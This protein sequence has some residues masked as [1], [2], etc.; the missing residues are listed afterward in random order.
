MALIT[1]Y[2]TTARP[3]RGII[4]VYDSDAYI[5]DDETLQNSRTQVVAGNGYHLY[6]HSLQPDIP[7]EIV[8]RIWDT[9]QQPP[10]DA[11]GVTAV[12]LEV[13][14]GLLVVNQL[15]Y[16]PAGEVS[17]PQP[18]VYGGHVAWKG[19]Q[20]TAAYYGS[21]IRRAAEEQWTPEQIGSSWGECSAAEQYAFDLWFIR[22]CEPDDDE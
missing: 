12:T 9:P 8:I 7:V 20:E 6:L 2:S 4:Q 19:R 22:E 16:G 11:E 5:G 3:D 14:T 21:T 10:E 15:S 1:H 13:A 17:L 18:G